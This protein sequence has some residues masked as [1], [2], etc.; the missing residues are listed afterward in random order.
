MHRRAI[1]KAKKGSNHLLSSNGD[2]LRSLLSM[3]PMPVR[4]LLVTVFMTI[5]MT[6]LFSI[7]S[8]VSYWLVP[9]SLLPGVFLGFTLYHF[10]RVLKEILI[11]LEPNIGRLPGYFLAFFILLLGSIL[12]I[13]IL[14]YFPS[15]LFLKGIGAEGCSDY[16]RWAFNLAVL[17]A[18]ILWLRIIFDRIR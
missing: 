13:S 3:S 15:A 10:D 8:K 9:F 12:I 16:G 6:L 14:L 5:L 4:F 11:S 18:I 17:V 7:Y 2:F 1:R